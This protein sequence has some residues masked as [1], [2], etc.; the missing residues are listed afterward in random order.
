VLCGHLH[1]YSFLVRRTEGGRF[2][3]LAISSV[4]STSDGRTKDTL[5]DVQDYRPDLVDLEPKHSPDTIALRRAN[6]AAERPFI[7]RFEYA[8]TWGHANLN[9]GTGKSTADVFRAL[10]DQP[11]KRI[12]LPSG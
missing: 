3:Q 12:D 4:A 9:I 1:K 6:L 5:D 8:D 2:C 10:A 11:W 7:E